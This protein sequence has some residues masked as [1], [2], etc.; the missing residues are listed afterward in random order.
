VAA[1]GKDGIAEKVHSHLL[2][3]LAGSLGMPPKTNMPD[4]TI[5]GIGRQRT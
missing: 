5:D 3:R 1:R 4:D 2:K